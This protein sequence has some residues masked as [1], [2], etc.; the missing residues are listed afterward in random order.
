MDMFDVWLMVIVG[1][2]AFLLRILDYPL[3]PAVLAI[4]LGP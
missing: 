3:A 1:V 2:I 4:V